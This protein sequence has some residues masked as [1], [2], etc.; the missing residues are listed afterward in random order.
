MLEEIQGLIDEIFPDVVQIRRQIHMFP[1]LRDETVKTASLVASVLEGVG[2]ETRRYIGGNG[3][4]GLIRGRYEKPCVALRADMDAL[5]IQ[6]ENDVPYRSRIDGVMHACGHDVHTAILAGVG[7][8]LNS[9]RSQIPG[10]VKLI[11]QPAEEVGTGAKAMIEEGVME[12]PHVDRIF[13]LHV[14][15]GLNVGEIGV[16]SGPAMANMDW[17]RIKI[18]GIGGHGAQPHQTR[19]PIAASAYLITQLQTIVSRSVSPIDPAVVTVGR[20]EGGTAC[21]I[22]PSEVKMEGTVRS[23]DPEVRTLI[24]ERMRSILNGI[25]LSMGVECDLSYEM[26][27]PVVYNDPQLADLVRSVGAEM[28]GED[29]VFEVEPSMG[30]EDFAFYLEHAPGV[31]FRI[32]V[33][34]EERGF[35]SQIHSPTF[36]VPEEAMKVG[37]LMMASLAIRGLDF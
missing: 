1:E 27:S 9:I 11:F 4:V 8:M 7:M 19:D 28:L 5:P 34:D 12:E 3:V 22:I 37:M 14:W 10:T 17:F 26:G 20:I 21:N 23:L 6:E 2:V 36:D 13:G 18:K 31:F 30:G 15:P 29:K 16:R 33:R 24:I 35:V 25:E 32:G